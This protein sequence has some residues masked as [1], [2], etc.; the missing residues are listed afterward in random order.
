[1]HESPL[2]LFYPDRQLLLVIIVASCNSIVRVDDADDEQLASL[3]SHLSLFLFLFVNLHFD[4]SRVAPDHLTLLLLLLLHF[5]DYYC[6]CYRVFVLV[7]SE[8]IIFRRN[9]HPFSMCNFG[10]TKCDSNWF[11]FIQSLLFVFTSITLF[12]FSSSVYLSSLLDCFLWV[13]C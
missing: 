4:C 11:I 9:V 3:I 6:C 5:H 12:S 8:E 13:N 1:M 2:R 7:M 10:P